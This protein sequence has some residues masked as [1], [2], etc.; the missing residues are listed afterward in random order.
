MKKSGYYSLVKGSMPSLTNPNNMSIIT[1][2]SPNLHG[3]CGN[4]FLDPLT[5]IP[6]MM[7]DSRFIKCK[8][9]I[10]SKFYDEGYK[11]GAVTGKNKLLSLLSHNLNFN[12][13]E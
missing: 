7:N 9:T 6:I 5:K 8:D 11:I 1:G 12:Q 10:L 13:H 3:I 2:V 4:Y